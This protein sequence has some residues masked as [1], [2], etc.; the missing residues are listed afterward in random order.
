MPRPWGRGPYLS[1]VSRGRAAAAKPRSL[2]PRGWDQAACQPHHGRSVD[3]TSVL[4][5]TTAWKFHQ[6]PRADFTPSATWPGGRE[7]PPSPL[8]GTGLGKCRSRGWGAVGI[9][10]NGLPES[11][12]S[13]RGASGTKEQGW[14]GTDLGVNPVCRPLAAP[15]TGVHVHTHTHAHTCTRI[16]NSQP[17]TLAS[18]LVKLSPPPGSPPS[19]PQADSG[20]TRGCHRLP[21]TPVVGVAPESA[22]APAL[23]G[24]QCLV[25]ARECLLNCS[26]YL[27]LSSLCMG[28]GRSQGC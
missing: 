27:L 3:S 28:A 8:Y 5:V 18:S 19:P 16:H 21:V 9:F 2:S 20:A 17:P 15:G 23:H 1:T 4:T 10:A 13:V 24:V 14:N 22:V 12:S 7:I 25:G 11:R 6:G 26:A